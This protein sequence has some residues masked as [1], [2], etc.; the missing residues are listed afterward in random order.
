MSVPINKRLASLDILRGFDLF[1]LVGLQPVVWAILSQFGT[2]GADAVMYQLDHEVWEGFRCWDLV[3]PLFLF[4][5][6]AA[7][8]FS[9]SPYIS[10]REPRSRAWRKVGRRFVVLFV[11]GMVVQGNLLSLQP[12]E[13]KLYT[14]TLQAIAAGYVIAAALL[15]HCRLRGQIVGVVL[16]LL[17][18]WLP[19]TLWGDYSP[20]GNLANRIDAWML[21]R[22]RGDP[23]YT[24][25]LSSLTFGVTTMLGAWAGQYVRSH[26]EQPG[27]TALV[28]LFIGLA[29]IA[30]GRLWGLQE[31]IIKRIWT[32]SMTLYSAGWCWVLL[33]LFYYLVD[34]K[35]YHRGLDWLKVYGMNAI[36]AY[37][38]GEVVSFRSIACSLLY[39]FEPL[40]GPY[41]EALI[42]AGNFALLYG[43]LYVLYKARVFIKI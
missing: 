32:C 18:Y 25:V 33:A 24:W 35:G 22:F 14:N 38:L 12:G 13:F 39:G 23:S 41:Y 21:G 3:M 1:L 37:M 30:A 16:L 2:P 42:T 10:G 27:R 28:L 31:P 20:E 11:L 29:L 17:A 43:L 36:T 9:L 7:M 40:C 26:R 5:C 6:G 4:M 8:P 19:M 34:V 15:L